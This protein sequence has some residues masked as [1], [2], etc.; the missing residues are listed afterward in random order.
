MKRKK[1]NIVVMTEIKKLGVRNLEQ[2]N[3]KYALG[4]LMYCPGDNEGVA[5]KLKSQEFKYLNTLVLCLEDAIL[6][7]NLEKAMNIVENTLSKITKEYSNH[8]EDLPF[9][10]I[11]VRN[12]EHLERCIKRYFKYS[13]VL[14]GF[15]LPKYDMEV[16]GYYKRIIN[17][18]RANH[19]MFMP[20][21]E[22]NSIIEAYNRREEMYKIKGI[23]DRTHDILGVLVGTNDMCNY[24]G[25]RRSVNQTVYDIG[26]I[27]DILNDIICVFGKDYVVNGP[28]WEY[29]DGPG[30]DEGLRREVELD[31]LN[32]FTGKSCVHPKQL[33]VVRDNIRVNQNDYDDACDVLNWNRENGVSRGKKSGRMNEIATH[34]TWADRTYIL[35]QIYG[36]CE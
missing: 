21:L 5:D 4:T 26:V 27:R 22:S 28:I 15:V 2:E 11:R 19:F 6:L 12:P 24:F 34:K 36:V 10:F 8:I 14:S 33:K 23:L 16:A 13:P 17:G 9:I 30:W 35:G 31:K 1:G 18:T 7:E 3:K 20:I 25:I 29:F 32:G